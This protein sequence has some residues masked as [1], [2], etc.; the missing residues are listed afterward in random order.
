MANVAWEQGYLVSVWE[1]W[2]VTKNWRITRKKEPLHSSANTLRWNSFLL[3]RRYPFSLF[4]QLHHVSTITL[5]SA[6][7]SIRSRQDNWTVSQSHLPWFRPYGPSDPGETTAHYHSH[8]YLDFGETT[9]HYHSHIYLDFGKTTAHYHSHIYLDFG[10]MIHQISARQLHIITVTFTLISAVWSIRSRRDNCTLSQSHLP[11]FR[12]Y[13]PSDPGETTAHYHNH[14]Y[15]DFG[16]MVHQIQAR[17]LHII[18]VTFTL[19]SAVWSIRSRR[20][21]CTLLQSHL[22]WFRKDNC[23]LSQSH[24]PWF[25]PYGPSD[26]GVIIAHYH[27]HIYLDF[28]HMVHQIQAW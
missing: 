27:S 8:I 26:P 7:W 10:R 2:K 15:L 11:W 1:K 21:N 16:R 12:P 3:I 5:I 22:P 28:G 17:Q 13:G 23:T 24:L 18:T 4:C 14:I 25:R 19:I 20:D 6:I 9:A